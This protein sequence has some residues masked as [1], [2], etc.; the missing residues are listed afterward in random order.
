MRADNNL[1]GTRYVLAVNSLSI[2]RVYYVEKMGFSVLN[3]YPGWTFL[4]RDNVILMLG[5]CKNEQSAHEIGDHSYFAYI[6]V[7]DASALHQEFKQQGIEFIKQLTDEPWGMR[8]FGIKTI[9]GHRMMF[10]EDS[11][12]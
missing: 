6:E 9:D 3:E 8:E 10:G 4:Q 5:E 1:E 2:S 7:K 12:R 11:D